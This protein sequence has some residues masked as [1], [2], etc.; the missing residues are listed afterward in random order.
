MVGLIDHIL[1][2]NYIFKERHGDQIPLDGIL[3]RCLVFSLFL[4]VAL[5][6]CGTVSSQLKYFMLVVDSSNG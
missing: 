5:P 4:H 6:L 3:V 2:K 1:D